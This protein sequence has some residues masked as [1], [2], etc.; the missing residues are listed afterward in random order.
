MYLAFERKYKEFT[1]IGVN[2]SI[3]KEDDKEHLYN[4]DDLYFKPNNIRYY[5]II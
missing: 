3:A 5:S 2:L 4:E 1:I